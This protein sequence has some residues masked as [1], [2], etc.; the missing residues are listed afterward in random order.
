MRYHFELAGIRIC[1]D[2]PFEL[3]MQEESKEFAGPWSHGGREASGEASPVDSIHIYLE[4]KPVD[5][6][7]RIHEQGHWAGCHCYQTEDENS[8]IFYSIE[9]GGAPYACA[10][11]NGEGTLC[12]C[13]YLKGKEYCLNYS[14]NIW[15]ILG[16]EDILLRHSG[17]LLHSS[18][19]RCQGKAVLFSAPCGTGKSTQAELWEKY[20]GADIVN[21]DRAG[22]RRLGCGWAAFGLPYAGSSGIYRN[23]SAP[24]AA[25]ILLRQAKENRL[26]KLKALEAFPDLYREIT[27]HRWDRNFVSE[28]TELL[29]QL[30]QEIPVY[31]LECRPDQEAVQLVRDEIF[32]GNPEYV[33]FRTKAV[34]TE[35]SKT[36][37]VETK[38]YQKGRKNYDTDTCRAARDRI[39]VSESDKTENSPGRDV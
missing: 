15:D 29:L 19:I 10:R 14:R 24:L 27:V 6:L 25:V 1:A 21:G 32:G 13:L 34:K 38:K 35:V 26:R 18:F 31:L 37:T 12:E 16:M 20:E 23:E 4:L 5:Q 28:S 39:S 33:T 7:P 9:Q 3:H 30:L 22:L 2:I 11:W 8:L 17:L 36:E